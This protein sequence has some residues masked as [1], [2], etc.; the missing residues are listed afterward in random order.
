MPAQCR[1]GDI[2]VGVCCCH[3]GCIGYVTTFITGASSPPVNANSL[4]A[5]IIGTIGV[6]SCGHPT[7]ALTG[8]ATVRHNGSGA[9]RIGDT[10]ANC[11]GPYTAVS[12]SPDVNA[13]G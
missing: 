9:H 13:G 6:S 3:S 7:T 8:S 11:G 4:I 1:V 2:G 5:C 12:G 10:G